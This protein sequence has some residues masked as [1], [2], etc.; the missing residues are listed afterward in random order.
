[1]KT[2]TVIEE[3]IAAYSGYPDRL[4]MLRETR[5]VIH[6]LKIEQSSMIYDFL[7]KDEAL[8]I[9]PL[10][11][12]KFTLA[13]GQFQAINNKK[14]FP[15]GIIPQFAIN[16]LTR[17]KLK[18]CYKIA[19]AAGRTWKVLQNDIK[20]TS[21]AVI[22]AKKQIWH[23]C[24]GKELT[25][26]LTFKKAIKDFNVLILGETGTGKDLFA[27]AIQYAAFWH[28]SDDIAP[29]A[30]VNVAAFQETLIE[31]ELFGHVKGAYTGAN[32]ERTG[33]ITRSHRGTF[34]LDEI[35]DLQP[36]LQ[37]KLLRV[38]ETKK[39]RKLGSDK[40]EDADV[41]YISATNKDIKN[42]TFRN[43]LYERLA[44]TVV[45]LPALRDR[46]QE[47]IEEIAKFI[48][49]QYLDKDDFPNDYEEIFEGIHN[50]NKEDYQW[51]GNVRE[52][53]SFIRGILLGINNNNTRL[54]EIKPDNTI[55]TA[56][57]NGQW[58]EAKLKDWYFKRVFKLTNKNMTKTSRILDVNPS[59]LLRR[60]GKTNE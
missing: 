26:S 51:P 58:S 37:V 56:L 14:V 25:S 16:A 24:F 4:K 41:R 21:P 44:G 48:M 34:F 30:S 49:L 35:G 60:R 59:T 36:E 29:T 47:D 15:D 50:R 22:E 2:K 39:T 13:L 31:S 19:S 54:K 33:L 11:I 10:A 42:G 1:M 3:T 40:E 18:K 53:Q 28:D 9:D 45:H 20:G 5:K 17:P 43:D 23:A 27:K 12:E 55:P 8:S 57:L 32:A 7:L 6:D 38:I 46:S 52:L